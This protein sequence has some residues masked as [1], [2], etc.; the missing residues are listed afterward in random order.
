MRHHWKLWHVPGAGVLFLLGFVSVF[1]SVLVKR[2]TYL[3]PTLWTLTP[4]LP[5]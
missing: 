3:N 5:G 1:D 4:V 2:V